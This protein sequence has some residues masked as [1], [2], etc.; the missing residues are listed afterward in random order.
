MVK[1]EWN[2]LKGMESTYQ[3]GSKST[4][5]TYQQ[6]SKSRVQRYVKYVFLWITFVMMFSPQC[7][8]VVCTWV[9]LLILRVTCTSCRVRYRVLVMLP[10]DNSNALIRGNMNV[11]FLVYRLRLEYSLGIG[12]RKQS[13]TQQSSFE[14][15]LAEKAIVLIP[16]CANYKGIE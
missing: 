13:A 11:S 14:E 3:Q 16:S 4:E 8:H 5:S 12:S 2:S 15:N 1:C 10:G 9:C 6:G 7:W